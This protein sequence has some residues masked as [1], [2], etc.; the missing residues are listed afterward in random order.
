M[1]LDTSDA[2]LTPISVT[3]LRQQRC[4][5]IKENYLSCPPTFVFSSAG[6]SNSNNNKND[7]EVDEKPSSMSYDEADVSLKNEDEKKRL[8]NQGFGLTDEVRIISM[9][10]KEGKNG[11]Q[12]SFSLIC[13]LN[14][15]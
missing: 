5:F 13:F 3:M 2:F 14:R 15:N 1:L 12:I 9:F 8:D 11:N 6:S 10:S 7:A 4:C